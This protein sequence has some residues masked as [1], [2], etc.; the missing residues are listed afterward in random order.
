VKGGPPLILDIATSV[1]A[2]GKIQVARNKHEKIAPGLVLDGRGRPTDDPEAFYAKPPGAILP[3][4]GHKGSGLSLFCEIL[5]GS[6]TG[7]FASNPAAPTAGRLVNNMTSL[8][9]DPAA[10][11]GT[12]FFAGDLARLMEWT[13]ASPPR[14]PGG[15]V[16]FPGEI[17]R[18]VRRERST[19]GVPL[20]TET[21]SQIRAAA[22][23]LGVDAG[24][25]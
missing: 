5:A 17:E 22:T 23:G 19:N 9:L 13:K 4:G 18:A 24:E 6:L 14:E 1:V 25:I 21:R 10:F 15:A 20:D 3:F 7:G 12:D 8:V 16:L 2:E 11:A